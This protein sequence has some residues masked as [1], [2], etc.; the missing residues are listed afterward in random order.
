MATRIIISKG[1]LVPEDWARFEQLVKALGLELVPVAYEIVGPRGPYGELNFQLD[2]EQRAE[3]MH[4]ASVLQ[5]NHHSVK[6]E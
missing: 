3:F 2:S 1:A 5:L 6:I 4:F